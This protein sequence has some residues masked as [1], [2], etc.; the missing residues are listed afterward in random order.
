MLS[1]DRRSIISEDNE[2]ITIDLPDEQKNAYKK[3]IP[4]K[5]FGSAQDVVAPVLFL[6]SKESSYITGSVLEVTG[7][8]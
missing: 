3:Q 1:R 4:L 7:G 8:L 5:R 6:A 2:D